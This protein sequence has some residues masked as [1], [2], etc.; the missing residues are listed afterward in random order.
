MYAGFGVPADA[1]VT[2]PDLREAL[3]D[4]VS[5]P[6]APVGTCGVSCSLT[7][8]QSPASSIAK[9]CF[10][11]LETRFSGVEPAG[12]G[13]VSSDPARRRRGRF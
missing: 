11:R 5:Q 10:Q 4:E 6:Q 7:E 13:S 9:T 3:A 8:I 2:T 12:V 1:I